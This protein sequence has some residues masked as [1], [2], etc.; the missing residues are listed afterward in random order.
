MTNFIKIY[1]LSLTSNS[2]QIVASF[3][4]A[5]L[6]TRVAFHSLEHE[7]DDESCRE[8]I[9]QLQRT[10][11]GKNQFKGPKIKLKCLKT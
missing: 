6:Q 2:N 5:N 11:W 10:Q 4:D 3:F 7:K 1:L 8:S 9:A